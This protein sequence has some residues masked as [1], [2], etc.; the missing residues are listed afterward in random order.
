MRP[1]PPRDLA[2]VG[3]DG[4]AL[5]IAAVRDGDG[6]VFHLDQIFEMDLA[7]VFDDLRAALVAEVLLDFLQLLHD[8]AAQHFLGAENFEILGDATLDIGQF[9]EDLLAAPCR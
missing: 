8:E 7:G 5:Q 6:D 1:L 3:I 2:P 4:G 9:V